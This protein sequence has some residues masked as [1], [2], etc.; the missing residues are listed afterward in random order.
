MRTPLSRA[1]QSAKLVSQ[2]SGRLTANEAASGMQ[3]K[4]INISLMDKTIWMLLVIISKLLAYDR[5][6]EAVGSLT[7][8]VVEGR[9]QQTTV[10]TSSVVITL[11]TITMVRVRKLAN[12]F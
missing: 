5:R 12:A 4:H 1:E 11:F 9:G 10:I 2:R 8:A 3:K 7:T 6:L